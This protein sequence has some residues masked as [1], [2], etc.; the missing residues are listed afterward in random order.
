MFFFYG[1]NK[2]LNDYL[3][4]KKDMLNKNGGEKAVNN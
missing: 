2:Y 3:K 1:L 4:L